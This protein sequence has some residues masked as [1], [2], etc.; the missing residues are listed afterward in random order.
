MVISNFASRS[1][2]TDLRSAVQPRGKAS[3][4]SRHDFDTPFVLN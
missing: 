1:Y 3:L 4:L 2:G